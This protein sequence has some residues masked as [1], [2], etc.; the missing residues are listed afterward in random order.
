MAG[1]A[2]ACLTCYSRH[3]PP[4]IA[5]GAPVNYLLAEGV[6]TINGTGI[7]KGAPHPNTALL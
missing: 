7:M 6:G 1:Q 3:Y 5:K 4:R 2:A